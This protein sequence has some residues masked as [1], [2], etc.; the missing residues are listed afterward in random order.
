MQR[1]GLD[2]LSSLESHLV[3]KVTTKLAL[4]AGSFTKNYR[5]LNKRKQLGFYHDTN[6]P[7]HIEGMMKRRDFL[8]YSAATS[9]GCLFTRSV[10]ASVLQENLFKTND[11]VLDLADGFSSQ[12][13]SRIGDK[14]SDG[15][16][17][18]G[19]PD[20]MACFPGPNN[21]LVLTRNHELDPMDFNRG[22]Y[23]RGQRPNPAAYDKTRFGGVTRVVLNADTLEVL[24]EN[25]ILVGT[26]RNCAGGMSPWGW[27]TCEETLSSRH[28]YVFLCDPS[29]TSAQ[30][31]TRITGYGR[32][33]HEAVAI[34]PATNVAYLTEDRPDGCLY[35][36]VPFRKSR[37]FSGRLEAL[38][39]VD[40]PRLKTATKL[41][42]GDKVSV[43]WVPVAEPTPNDDSVRYQSH[44]AGAAIFMRGEGI[45]YFENKVYFTAT[46]GGKAEKGQVFCLELG[47]SGKKQQLSVI[48]EARSGNNLDMPDNITVSPHGDVYVAEDGSGSQ[49]IRLVNAKGQSRDLCRN[50]LSDSEIAGICFSPDGKTM[51]ANIQ[52]DGLT[53]AI[54]GPF[55]TFGAI[56]G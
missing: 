19:K 48:S 47:R 8:T 20:G 15:Y 31:A 36:F 3:D 41:N 29:A 37:P 27:L 2:P 34:D 51:F 25:L 11:S 52:S 17:V 26:E 42:P 32:Y 35:R 18:P 53:V 43:E 23:R 50:R 10:A 45:W 28:G 30:P 24:S 13:L 38:K 49:Y 39:V 46:T 5:L 54:R 21:T 7:K 14:M 4:Q 6:I 9:L 33:N 55:K 56:G 40:R 44:E 12:I 16:I 22:P 1:R